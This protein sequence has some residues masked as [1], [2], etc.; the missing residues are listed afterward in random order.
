MTSSQEEVEHFSPYYLDHRGSGD[1]SNKENIPPLTK[2]KRSDCNTASDLVR[3]NGHNDDAPFSSVL[4]TN[5]QKEM[6][7]FQGK[8]STIDKHDHEEVD[9]DS[10][11]RSKKK[12]DDDKK[13]IAKKKGNEIGGGVLSNICRNNRNK[14]YITPKRDQLKVVMKNHNVTKT[15]TARMSE[16]RQLIEKEG[17]VVDTLLSPLMNSLHLGGENGIINIIEVLECEAVN[18]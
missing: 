11:R 16:Q 18:K 14:N 9:V 15:R 12:D 3:G 7:L 10:G 6:K 2:M 17:Q 1:D 13:K 8:K 4:P 5:S